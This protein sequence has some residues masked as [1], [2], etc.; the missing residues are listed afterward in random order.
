MFASTHKAKGGAR[1]ASVMP[2]LLRLF[3][4]SE[5]LTV[6]IYSDGREPITGTPFDD[7]INEAF[8][9]HAKEVA[10]AD[11]A[12]VTVLAGRDGHMVK[13]T[14]NSSASVSLPAL[15]PAKSI[16][17]V[18]AAPTAATAPTAP[19]PQPLPPV[20]KPN[21]P[22]IVDY[23]RSNQA[24]ALLG[25]SRTRDVFSGAPMAKDAPVD[26][27]R[28]AAP[29][30]NASPT[31][32]IAPPNPPPAPVTNEPPVAIN[33]PPALTPVVTPAPA[34]VVPA[35]TNAPLIVVYTQQN[36]VLPTANAAAESQP[37][38]RWRLWL[39]LALVAVIALTGYAGWLWMAF[40]PRRRGDSSSLI[41]RSFDKDAK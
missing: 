8:R 24:K 31:P 29:S 17:A 22:L 30:N 20:L 13:C 35:K 2:E 41:T 25:G 11:L 5:S 4:A 38:L 37:A 28:P 21:P 33:P 7:A 27:S 9:D 23:S 6:F 3:A 15:P 26:L 14:M 18:A 12:F 10:A 34:V 19:A 40:T 39:G 1:V 36:N 16:S 32:I